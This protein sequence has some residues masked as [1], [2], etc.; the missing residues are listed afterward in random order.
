MIFN[1]WNNKNETDQDN[2]KK[3]S[4]NDD[5]PS[6]S[7]PEDLRLCWEWFGMLSDIRRVDPSL[8]PDSYL[9]NNKY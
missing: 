6:T 9:A 7:G 5:C 3:H 1:Y 2:S 8:Y 4:E